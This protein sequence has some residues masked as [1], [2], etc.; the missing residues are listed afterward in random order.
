VASAGRP[1][2]EAGDFHELLG[3]DG[4]RIAQAQADYCEAARLLTQARMRL[5]ARFEAGRT[6]PAIAE[7]AHM[8]GDRETARDHLQEAHRI[9]AA[10]RVERYVRRAEAIVREWQLSLGT[11][12]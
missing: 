3:L 8:Q 4:G 7:L 5:A 12:G 11:P 2:A 9:F 10:L 1:L 6:Q